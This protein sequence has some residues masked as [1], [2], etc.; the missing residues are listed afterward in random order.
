[1]A[2]L[3][4]PLP[5]I[6]PLLLIACAVYSSQPELG[7][8]RLLRSLMVLFFHTTARLLK[9]LELIMLFDQPTIVPLSLMSW[10]LLMRLFPHST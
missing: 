6:C 9:E 4:L 3:C 1:M 8:I 2:P 7:G 5:T 10:A